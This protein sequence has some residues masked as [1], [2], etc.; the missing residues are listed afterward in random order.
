MTDPVEIIEEIS[1]QLSRRTIPESVEALF[2]QLNPLS[3]G[4]KYQQLVLPFG[5]RMFRITKWDEKPDSINQL[6]AP[7]PGRS[8]LGR[9][10]DVGESVLYLADSPDTAFRE[11]AAI[12]GEVCLSEGEPTSR[13]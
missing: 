5:A 11:V 9:L 12:S 7:P 1:T 2:E 6:G 13:S 10:N 8:P 4:L 3:I